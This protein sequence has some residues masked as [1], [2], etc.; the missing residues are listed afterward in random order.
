MYTGFFTVSNRD[1]V[2]S[3]VYIWVVVVR[4]QS[5]DRAMVLGAWHQKWN[6]PCTRAAQQHCAARLGKT[7]PSLEAA[8]PLW[9]TTI[10]LFV[11]KLEDEEKKIPIL[12]QF[13]LPLAKKIVLNLNLTI[14]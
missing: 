8:H 13:P 4:V 7:R 6:C 14:E 9:P 10:S 11:F 12:H 2:E 3:G 5:T 1:R